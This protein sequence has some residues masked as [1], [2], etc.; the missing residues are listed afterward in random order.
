MPR[1]ATGRLTGAVTTIVIT[2]KLEC[3]VT[4]RAD[5]AR[6]GPDLRGEVTLFNM[7]VVR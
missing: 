7:D 2:L 1:S 6:A 5:L 4:L 3:S